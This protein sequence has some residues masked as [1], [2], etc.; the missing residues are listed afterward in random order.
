MYRR[1]ETL[2]DAVWTMSKMWRS[3]VQRTVGEQLIRAADSIG[4]NIAEASGRYHPGEVRQFLF[5]ARGS[6]RETVYWLR[7]VAVR[8]LAPEGS[9]HD[10]QRELDQL[11]REINLAIK[12]QRSRSGQIREDAPS[13]SITDDFIP[14]DD[15]D[16]DPE[17]RLYPLQPSNHP[18]I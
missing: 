7:R 17:I 3:D 13:Y 2:A 4:A 10:L 12:Y 11:G 9:I 14:N 1:A 5:Y 15:G 8:Q 16:S 18:T 6:L